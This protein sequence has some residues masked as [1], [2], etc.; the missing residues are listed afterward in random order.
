[1]E[2]K[3]G[4]NPE[5]AGA[6][7][8]LIVSGNPWEAAVAWVSSTITMYPTLELAFTDSLCESQ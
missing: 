6:M 7:K 4:P 5:N 3:S 8:C 2:F 1:M